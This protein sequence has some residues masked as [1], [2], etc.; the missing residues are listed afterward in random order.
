[1]ANGGI[2][3]TVNNPT[4]TTATGVW[5]QEEQYEAKVTDT[6]PQRALFTTKSCRFNDGSSDNLSRSTGTPS[7]R[8]KFTFSTWIK[9]SSVS[10]NRSI[11]NI[12][13]DGNTTLFFMVK[14]GDQLHF[15]DYNS[16]AEKAKLTTTAVYRDPSAWYHVVLRLD[17][18]QGTNTNRCRLYV[19]GEQITSFSATVYPSQNYNFTNNVGNTR[20]GV[21]QGN[22][23]YWDGYITE[24]IFIDGQSLAPTSFGVANSD[25]VWTPIIY[26]GTY[27][28]NGFNLQFED[29]AA[30]GT[31][32]S[33]NGNTFTVN[34]LTSIDQSTDYPVVNYSTFNPL[35]KN[36]A[37]TVTFSNGNLTVAH[38]GSDSRYAAYSAIGAANGKWYMEIKIDAMSGT[39]VIVG[40]GSN[41][42]EINRLGTYYGTG[43]D[44]TSVGY[45]ASDG[46]KYI[47]DVASSYGNSFAVGDII[48]IAMDLDNN[49]LYFSKNGTFQNSGNP[50]SGATGTGAIALTAN[51]TY[52]M[53]ASHATTTTRTSTYSGNF[54]SPSF[55][56]S[57]S[58]A[59]GNGYGN[60]EYAVPSGYYAL[61]TAN[62]AE[63]G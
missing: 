4:S 62:L 10:G 31:D 55:A 2:I 41:V 49:K 38:S 21:S 56:I 9:L 61:N 52:F 29:A 47:D 37:G 11:F 40:V 39:D 3:G 59:D 28:T 57:S 18:T 27:G 23:N 63:F 16:S 45:F 26:S 15:V 54:G 24:S 6:W 44:P 43:S 1:M 22:A 35:S 60:F 5:Q 58:N 48:G 46:D 32:S 51:L 36:D 19:N 7:S 14:N 13:T 25:G 20:I 53:G 17:S 12:E 34:N 50:T 42:E 8:Q 30:L 33:P